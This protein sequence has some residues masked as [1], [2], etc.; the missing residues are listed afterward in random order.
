MRIARHPIGV[1]AREKER[2]HI[3]LL[4]QRRVQL[5]A[6]HARHDD[7]AH[8]SAISAPRSRNRIMRLGPVGGLQHAIPMLLEDPPSGT[9]HHLFVF[10][11]QDRLGGAFADQQRRAWRRIR[12]RD[13][14]QRQAD[15]HTRT[16]AWRAL[17]IN[18]PIMLLHQTVDHRH[19]ESRAFTR[20]LGREER[21]EEMCEDLVIHAAAGILDRDGHHRPNAAIGPL[22]FGLKAAAHGEYAAGGH[23]IAGIRREVE[24]HVLHGAGIGENA[25]QVGRDLSPTP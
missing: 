4:A 1:A 24:Q 14:R 8:D 6:A 2:H 16:D 5:A 10:D 17:H 22:H 15:G 11:Q 12:H 20:G 19:A 21:F 18:R 9:A 7:I 25:G 23:R 3:A 13:F